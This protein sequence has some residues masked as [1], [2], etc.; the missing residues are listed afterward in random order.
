MMTHMEIVACV[1]PQMVWRL[2]RR[3][4]AAESC[5]KLGHKVTRSVSAFQMM[6]RLYGQLRAAAEADVART[7]PVPSTAPALAP[8][9]D[10]MDDEL[11]DAAQVQ[12]CS[13]S[14]PRRG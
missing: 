5:S 10:N 9:A 6:R 12:F 1:R 13:K 14:T 11:D 7:L 4:H 3:L 8:H 2:N